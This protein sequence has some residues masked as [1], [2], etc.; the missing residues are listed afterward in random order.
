MPTAS[1]SA[2]EAAYFEARARGGA[3]LLIVGNVGIASPAGTS[4]GR[5]TAASDDERHLPGLTDLAERVH[6]H[7]ALVAAQL[8]HQGRIALLDVADGRPVLVPYIPGPPPPDPLMGMVTAAES[9]GMMAAFTKPGAKFEY[10]VATENDLSWVIARYVEAADR[11][12]RAGFDGVEIHAGH[13]YLIDEFLSPGNTRDD[14]WGGTLEGRA[15]LLVEVLRAIRKRVGRDFPL[16]I[17][18]NAL[19]PHK[20][21]GETLGRPAPGDRPRGGR[22]HRRGTRH[23]V[24]RRRRPGP[25]TRTRRTSSA[26]WPTTQPLPSPGC[27]CR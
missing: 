16:W 21:N 25:P 27:R 12:V 10:R 17:R 3:A 7:G 2:N 1:V 4:D 26:R 23:R 22:G 9:A 6:R 14:G 15:R 18:I 8:N 5:M 24:R 11:C 20:A 13:G 19:E